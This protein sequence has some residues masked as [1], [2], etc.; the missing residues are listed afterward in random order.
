MSY[1]LSKLENGSYATNCYLLQ[2][3]TDAAVIDCGVFDD[4]FDVF[5]SSHGVTS[6]RYIL[7][8]HGHFDHILGVFA[9]REKYGG[10]IV[11]SDG[12][13]RCLERED[14]SLNAFTRYGTQTPVSRDRAAEEGSPLPFGDSEISVLST[15][16]H[17]RGG[18]CYL[19]EDLL[20][21]GD[22]LFS[23]SMGRTDMPGGDTLA[24]LRSLA[25]LSELPQNYRVLPGHGP[26]TTLFSEKRNNP[27]LR[28]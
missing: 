1:T 12:D 9:L 5:L 27:F 21:S 17:T 25:K 7:L 26:E 6:L 15:P 20:F 8:T 22:T 13:R 4:A 14:F 28:R 18:V 11:I 19:F 24:L 23:R 2:S 16:G 3:G 10:E